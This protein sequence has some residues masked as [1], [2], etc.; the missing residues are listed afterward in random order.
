MPDETALGGEQPQ[1]A[2]PEQAIPNAPIPTPPAPT[3]VEEQPAAPNEPE[4]KKP[5]PGKEEPAKANAPTDLLAKLDFTKLTDKQLD[6]VSSGDEARVQAVLDELGIKDDTPPAPAK[7]PE[8]PALDKKP[9]EQ[10]PTPGKLERVSLKGIKQH[11]QRVKLAEALDL[12]RSGQYDNIDDAVLH[13]FGKGKSPEVAE[14]PPGEKKLETPAPAPENS[15][16]IADL[17]KQIA[18]VNAE[19]EVA[20]KEYDYATERAKSRELNKLEIKL[21]LENERAER[22]KAEQAANHSN[23][24]RDEDASRTRVLEK[25][26][27][28]MTD[29][30]SGFSSHVEDEILL[31]EAKSDSILLKPDWPEKIA[32]RVHKK[33]FG[34]KQSEANSPGGKPEDEPQIPALPPK[35]R[36]PGAPL[37]GLNQPAAMSVDDALRQLDSLPEDQRL[38]VL[39]MADKLTQRKR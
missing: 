35:V 25:F 15:Q 8:V 21:A 39:A 29:P 3:P 6:E 12:V 2:A 34:G 10:P 9:D 1:P 26:G 32:E 24:Q 38:E 11:E 16:S 33:F 5:E 18:D 28:L 27:E 20:A 19:I 22:E 17:E 7:T 36:M 13:V 30:D 14:T 31:A 4:E 23:F 37:G